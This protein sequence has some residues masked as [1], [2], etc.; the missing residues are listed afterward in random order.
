MN[1]WSAI[2]AS[3]HYLAIM[4]MAATLA[5]EVMTLKGAVTQAAITRLARVDMFYG[6]SA[7]LVLA[8][9]L[10]RVLWFGK[11][12]D[13]YLHNVLFHI[14]LTIFLAVALWSILPTVRFIRWNAA[15]KAS[16]SLPT[17]AQ[18]NSMR[19]VVFSELHLLALLPILAA[20]MARGFG[21]S[22]G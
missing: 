17:A 8:T 1:V 12:A 3:L 22:G 4:G 9:G 10:A 11:G 7:L 19:K 2:V 13:F 6:I 21:F 20:F 18:F 15:A 14:K 16:G 5:L